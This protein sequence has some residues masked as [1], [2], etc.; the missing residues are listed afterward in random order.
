MLRISGRET[1]GFFDYL[2]KYYDGDDYFREFFE[3][4]KNNRIVGKAATILNGYSYGQL[5][6]N[7]LVYTEVD[8]LDRMQVLTYRYVY[9]KDYNTEVGYEKYCCSSPAR[10]ICDYFMYQ[11]ELNAAMNIMDAIE[12]YDDDFNG[13]FTE[14]YEMMDFFKIDRKLLEEKIPLIGIGGNMYQVDIYC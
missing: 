7:I 13:D 2:D 14:V 1:L 6:G 9:L 4:N 5:L 11:K 8:F 10:N 12:G 3:R